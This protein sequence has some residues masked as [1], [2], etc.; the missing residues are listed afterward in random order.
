MAQEQRKEA[1][2][3]FWQLWNEARVSILARWRVM[4]FETLPSDPQA[5]LS[6]FPDVEQKSK[7]EGRSLKVSVSSADNKQVRL[8][9]LSNSVPS[10][11]P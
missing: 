2:M 9:I 3:G 11:Y 1:S 7:R 5:A 6:V 8:I 10:F 4:W